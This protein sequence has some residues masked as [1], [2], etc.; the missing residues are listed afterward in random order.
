MSVNVYKFQNLIGNDHFHYPLLK[1]RS[2]LYLD[3]SRVRHSVETI[4]GG[5]GI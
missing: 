1:L 4:A 3:I 5:S 2:R